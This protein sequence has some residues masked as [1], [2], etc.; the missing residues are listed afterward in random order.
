MALMERVSR[1]SLWLMVCATLAMAGAAPAGLQSPASRL[2]T[3]HGS[4]TSRPAG[5][6]L[7]LGRVMDAAR[8]A[9]V[10]GAIV[11]LS[12]AGS[13]LPAT[14]SGAGSSLS[15]RFAP[16]AVVTGR[17]GQFLFRDLPGGRFTF[18]VLAPGFLRGGGYGVLRPG[19]ASQV[20]RLDDGDRVGDVTLRVWRGA[21][22]TGKVSGEDGDPLVG[23]PVGA[24][25][26][27]FPGALRRFGRPRMATTDDR[28]SYRI[29]GLIPGEYI[30]YVPSTQT[31]IPVAAMIEY[32]RNRA[33]G[34]VLGA[35]WEFG[36]SGAPIPYGTG[37]RVGDVMWMRTSVLGETPLPAPDPGPAGRL[38]AYPTTFYGN[39][40]RPDAA[41]IITLRSG[42]E[43]SGVDLELALVPA[44]RVVGHVTGPHGPAARVGVHLEPASSDQVVSPQVLEAATTITDSTGA[45]TMLGVPAGRYT[46]R[47]ID[48]P[49]PQTASTTTTV[50]LE[51]RSTSALSMVQSRGTGGLSTDP[52]LWATVP[53]TVSDDGVPDI[54]VALHP[55][56]RV[57]GRLVYDGKIDALTAN[58]LQR[59]S[60]TLERADGRL[61]EVLS[62]DV[63]RFD[64]SGRFTSVGLEPGAYVLRLSG[65]LGPWRL[66]SA[67]VGGVDISDVPLVVGSSDIG[68][69][70][71]TLTDRPATVTGTV[72]DRSGLPDRRATVLIFPAGR[73][74]SVE[75]RASCRVRATRVARDGHYTVTVPPGDYVVA[76]L[77]D[78]ATDGWQAPNVLES[79]TRAGVRIAVS[80]GG[81]VSM[82]LETVR[83]R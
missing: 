51:G 50:R 63:A 13:P 69:V 47:V 79:L 64:A 61:P 43:R 18:T 31:T 8:G 83:I 2:G 52:T 44:A 25:R 21:S 33:P 53:I 45:F 5:R 6:G 32:E 9:P 42:D 59:L 82:D 20:L 78:D 3:G 56:A 57:S 4:A 19:G 77:D 22:L 73:P 38:R 75:M 58:Q 46:V 67:L 70:L 74:P 80:R 71:I 66:Q 40:R 54:E 37:F 36:A 48:V 10:S 26:V 23:A 60:L 29:G 16:Q 30:V 39:V 17:T 55:G 72:R 24:F 68:S 14:L 28:G 76:A 11:T 62:A 27:D 49:Q 81:N 41:S 34:G 35:A 12:P 1:E 65:N 15:P 7:I